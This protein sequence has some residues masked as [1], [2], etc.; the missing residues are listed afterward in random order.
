M[1]VRAIIYYVATTLI[2]V[3]IGVVMVTI[4]K[5]GKGTRETPMSASGRAEPVTTA[6]AFLDLIR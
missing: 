6:D 2:A 5:P 4:I 1:G 3:F